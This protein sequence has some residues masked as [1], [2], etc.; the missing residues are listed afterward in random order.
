MSMIACEIC[1]AYINTDDDPDA[2]QEWTNGE[3]LVVC[4]RCRGESNDR[5]LR[6]LP[7]AV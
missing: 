3:E 1:G 6:P 5:D 4:A 7:L 2:F